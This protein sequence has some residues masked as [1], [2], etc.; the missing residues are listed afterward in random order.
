VARSVD[1][2]PAEDVYYIGGF[3]SVNVR[4]E[5]EDDHRVLRKKTSGCHNATQ[6]I[7]FMWICHSR[8]LDDNLDLDDTV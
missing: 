3:H 6:A 1:G 8:C 2:L 5:V 7:S 4:R